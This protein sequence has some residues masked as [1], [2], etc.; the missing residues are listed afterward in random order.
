[1]INLNQDL[2]QLTTIPKLQFDNINKVQTNL[3]CHYVAEALADQEPVVTVDIGIGAILIKVEGSEIKYKFIPSHKLENNIKYTVTT[4][5]SPLIEDVESIIKER[6]C[7]AYK[8][9][10]G[11]EM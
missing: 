10:F 8:E 3:I 6:I 5:E 9:L 7:N 11:G 4:K 2:S 1:M